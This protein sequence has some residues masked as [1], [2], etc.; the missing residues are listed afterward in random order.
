[1]KRHFAVSFAFVCVFALCAAALADAPGKLIPEA[2]ANAVGM[3]RAWF[4]QATLLRGQEVVTSVTFQDGTLFVTTEN[5]RLQAFDGETGTTLWT[6]EVG[7]GH[8]LPPGVN[9]K[10]VAAICGTDLVIY[11]RF[12]GKKLSETVLYGN[13]SAGPVATER[14]VYVPLFSQ[15]LNSYPIV[16]DKQDADKV[17]KTLNDMNEGAKDLGKA[18]DYWQKKFANINESIKNASYAIENIDEKRP[19]SCASFGTPMVQP[20]VGTQSYDLDVVGWTTDQG[21]LILG[22]ML[23]RSDDDPFKLLYK[24]QARPNFSYVNDARIG[25]KALIPRDDVESSPFFMPEDKSMQNMRLDEKRRKGGMF[26]IGSESG[27]VYAM[28]DV[29]GMLRWTFLTRKP[30]SQRISAFDDHAYIP[31]ESGDLFAVELK[32]G[33]EAWNAPDVVKTVA[34]SQARLYVVDGRGRLVSIDR[35]TGER[36]KVLNIGQTQFQVFNQETDRVYVV[37]SDG[38]IQCLHETQLAEPIRHREKLADINARIMAEMASET[39][40]PEEKKA[41]PVVEEKAAPAAS[42]SSD[43]EEDDPFGDDSDD[44]EAPADD[45]ADEADSAN[46]EDDPF[47]GSSDDEEDPF[48][49]DF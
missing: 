24:F 6:V 43:D 38:L 14:E 32:T 17:S 5:G 26:I 47:G 7:E 13:P 37:S 11:D 9:S 4:A 15:R 12:T 18:S 44:A 46:E 34:A 28:N 36:E 1:M 35:A 41:A 48:G 29:T 3:T 31:T 16:T 19:Y 23:R 40:A 30:V 25:N 21:W 20:I 39:P 49:G 10:I 8:L 2:D 42:A 27:H 22:E 45:V 33:N